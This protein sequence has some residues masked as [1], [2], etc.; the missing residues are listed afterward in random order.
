MYKR[1]ICIYKSLFRINKSHRNSFIR[2]DLGLANRDNIKSNPTLTRDNT[3][4]RGNPH[5]RKF[6]GTASGFHGK[7]T[8]RNIQNW[9]TVE[10][11]PIFNKMSNTIA[12]QY[13]KYSDNTPG[14]PR[15]CPPS[16]A[17]HLQPVLSVLMSNYQHCCDSLMLR[18]R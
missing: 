4:P 15:S 1:I 18:C 16:C 10:I 12:K 11:G 2:F 13:V 17:L 6:S 8:S 9:D 7:Q 14:D 3:N 5:L